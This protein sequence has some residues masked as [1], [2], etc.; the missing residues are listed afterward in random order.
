[1]HSF[2]FEEEI[3]FLNIQTTK[4]SNNTFSTSVYRKKILLH[5]K[6]PG[7]RFASQHKNLRSCNSLP[8]ELSKFARPYAWI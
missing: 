7:T 1:M 8:T 3:W 5:T 2:I 4:N 6:F